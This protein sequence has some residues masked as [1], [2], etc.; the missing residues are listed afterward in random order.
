MSLEVKGTRSDPRILAL[1]N[2]FPFLAKYWR[3]IQS[4]G[5]VYCKVQ[6]MGFDFLEIQINR[7]WIL[8]LFSSILLFDRPSA[9]LLLDDDGNTVVSIGRMGWRS[10][11]ETV[12]GAMLRIGAVNIARVRYALHIERSG[13]TIVYKPPKDRAIPELLA[14]YFEQ[15]TRT[16][17]KDIA[18][19]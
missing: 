2:E 19:V 7:T 4:S 5:R 1:F 15:R 17:E 10:K 12:Y 3:R 18:D 16:T 8:D 9:L 11:T 6:R 13:Q 14:A